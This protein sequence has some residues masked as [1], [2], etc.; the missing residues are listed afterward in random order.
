M[1]T[2]RI[3]G[4]AVALTLLMT[5]LVL[6]PKGLAQPERTYIADNVSIIFPDALPTSILAPLLR[7]ETFEVPVERRIAVVWSSHDTVDVVSFQLEVSRNFTAS[8][9]VSLERVPGT[10]FK[11]AIF[12]RPPDAS[13]SWLNISSFRAESGALTYDMTPEALFG[14]A[15]LGWEVGDILNANA[16][17]R[18][19]VDIRVPREGKIRYSSLDPVAV[20]GND[21]LFEAKHGFIYLETP[22][23]R[24]ATVELLVMIVFGI[25]VLFVVGGS[26]RIQAG[27]RWALEKSRN[28]LR[29]M[30]LSR[31]LLI[32]SA[33]FLLTIG[34]SYLV[35]P[36]PRVNMAAITGP[37]GE[38]VLSLSGGPNKVLVVTPRSLELML[39]FGAADCIFIEDYQFPQKHG[40]RW[41]TDIKEALDRGVP[42]FVGE[43][44]LDINRGFFSDFS[45]ER[46]P[47]G[48]EKA[49]LLSRLSD[50]QES[51]I[52]ENRMHLGWASFF[53]L[54]ILVVFLSM[55]TISAGAMAAGYVT[56]QYRDRVGSSPNR[57]TLCVVSFFIFFVLSVVLYMVSSYLLKMP[58][59]WHGPSGSG[60]TAISTVSSLFG[61]G[62]FPRAMFA[63]LGLLVLLVLFASRSKINISFS[64]LGLLALLS[65]YLVVSTPLTAPILF[66]FISGETPNTPPKDYFSRSSTNSVVNV[67]YR[68]HD[69]VAALFM[70]IFGEDTIEMWVS[71]G[72]IASL[73][74]AGTLFLLSRTSAATNAFI[75]PGLF[76][77]VSRLFARVGDLQLSKSLWTLPTSLALAAAMAIVIKAVDI[78]IS[79]LTSYLHKR[80][81]RGVQV[82][83]FVLVPLSVGFL[84]LYDAAGTDNLTQV[85][86]GWVFMVIAA[87]S[88]RNP[89]NWGR[90]L[91]GRE[92]I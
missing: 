17:V 1:A 11:R 76:L 23:T 29:D 74:F 56:L 78:P 15:Q 49:Y 59:G 41:W 36:S 5:V 62:N 18:T 70:T 90:I 30:S 32:F 8:P 68:F 85:L 42:V 27:R 25:V 89:W 13:P 88:A 38:Y 80:R 47:P 53:P 73:A 61:G 79:G 16:P 58:I 63:L 67:E 77:I 3:F 60:I 54:L 92:A 51:K 14:R 91:H 65:L 84:L 21:Y 7:V 69:A 6:L 2:A 26:K 12:R 31:L 75:I 24:R 66:R 87:I 37:K 19:L 45:V 44:A 72:M 10:Y 81:N 9:E 43:T 71:R 4:R 39:R 22:E 46:I 28:L 83:I 35:G 20:R 40:G 34:L 86:L 33:L 48:D 64:L 55:L 52:S 82:V 50:I 57:L